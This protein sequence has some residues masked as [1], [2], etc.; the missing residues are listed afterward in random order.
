MVPFELGENE[1]VHVGEVVSDIYSDA[2]G[3]ALGMCVL[4]AQNCKF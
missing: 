4:R 2:E 1:G 3:L